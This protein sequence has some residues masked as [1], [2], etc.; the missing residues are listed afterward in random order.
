[1]DFEAQRQMTVDY[2]FFFLLIL[3]ILGGIGIFI[4]DRRQGKNRRGK[5]WIKFFV[6]FLI[7]NVLF[8]SVFYCTTLFRI[9]CALIIGGGGF[10]LIRLQCSLQKI[11]FVKF[12]LFLLAYIITS[13]LFIIFSFSEQN[14]LL[15]T[16]LI[17]C[18]FD[19]FSQLSGQLFGKRKICPRVSPNKTL[20][21][22]IGGII[23]S[24]IV[25]MVVGYNMGWKISLS[26][27]MGIG[28]ALASFAGD[29]SASYVKRQYNVKDFGCIFPEHGGILDRFD[30]LMFAGTFVCILQA[31]CR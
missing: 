14:I 20:G 17:V 28:I 23:V 29:L 5:A 10:E 15:F 27:S 9:F 24:G 4:V 25:S 1:M 8:I 19:A 13:V 22:T 16:L 3:F 21:G 26:I 7:V 30:S 12:G 2:L 6:Y 11:A 31:F 18:S